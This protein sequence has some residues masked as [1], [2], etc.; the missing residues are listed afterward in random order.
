MGYYIQTNDLKGKAQQI[1]DLHGGTIIPHPDN[2]DEQSEGLVCV[3]DNGLFEAAVYVYSQGEFEAFTLSS[4]HRP[5]TWVS[6][7][8][9]KAEELSG[10]RRSK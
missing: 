6:M 5:K 4:D 10:F 8:K 1:V 3:V 7:D 9:D 2:F